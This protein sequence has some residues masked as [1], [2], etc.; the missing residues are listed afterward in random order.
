MNDSK[1][2][3]FR[4][5]D[6]KESP[7]PTTELKELLVVY[8]KL[9]DLLRET[10]DEGLDLLTDSLVMSAVRCKEKL[11]SGLDKKTGQEMAKEMRE[12]LRQIPRS[13]R[14]LLPGIGPR[15]GESLEQKLGIQF[16][17]F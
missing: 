2:L 14:S 8:D 13:L 10:D 17:A 16:S 4:R 15:L 9:T 7:A 6:K 12:E 5:S 3:P 1:V 11:A